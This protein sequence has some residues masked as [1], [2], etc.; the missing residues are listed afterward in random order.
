MYGTEILSQVSFYRRFEQIRRIDVASRHHDYRALVQVDSHHH[1]KPGLVSPR[2]G[3]GSYTMSNQQPTESLRGG[4]RVRGTRGRGGFKLGRSRPL[5]ITDSLGGRVADLSVG[6][7]P[8]VHFAAAVENVVPVASYSWLNKP[9][10]TIMVP[11]QLPM[12]S[13]LLLNDRKPMLFFL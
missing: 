11:C 12:F 2:F 13:F 5:D 4:S 6:P 3:S 8:S 1:L 10:A 9:G 7:N